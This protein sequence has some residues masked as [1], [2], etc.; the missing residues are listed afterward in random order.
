[1]KSGYSILPAKNHHLGLPARDDSF[2]RAAGQ[3][4]WA[5]SLIHMQ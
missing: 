2:D 1:M 4:H 5:E 3:K